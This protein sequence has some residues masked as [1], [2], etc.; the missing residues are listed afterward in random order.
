VTTLFPFLP[1]SQA[2]FIFQPTL[3]GEVYNATVT[4]NLFGR[5]YY[6]NL[7]QL[8]GTLV[9]CRS[10]VGSPNGVDISSLSWAGGRVTAVSAAPHGYKIGA[11][12]QL[13]ISGCLP[14]VFNGLQ[15]SFVTGSTTFSYPLDSDPGGFTQLG[16][17]AYDVSLTSGYFVSTMVFREAAQTFEV[18]P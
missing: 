12:V 16:V 9:V 15:D 13:T 5:R 1:S 10:V 7:A 8:D 4:W 6:L 3:D 18:S 2:P 11:I 14:D 17:A